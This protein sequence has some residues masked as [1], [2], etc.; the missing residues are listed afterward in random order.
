VSLHIV[1]IDIFLHGS[2][3][4]IS[5]TP[6]FLEHTS[7]VL[8]KEIESIRNHHPIETKCDGVFDVCHGGTTLQ[9][10]SD[11]P[12]HPANYT[13]S[14]SSEAVDLDSH[15]D[16]CLG[17]TCCRGPERL[18]DGVVRR[19]DRRGS[20]VKVCPCPCRETPQSGSCSHHPGR[21]WA[22]RRVEEL[23]AREVVLGWIHAQECWCLS[24]E[25]CRGASSRRTRVPSTHG[26]R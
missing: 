2:S 4:H 3:D 5:Q 20:A 14:Q 1:S 15:R 19:T 10:T 26:R 7:K 8:P 24:V 21:R 6:V 18:P 11:C 22:P 16:N 13:E 17:A 12:A 9:I 23:F 25:P